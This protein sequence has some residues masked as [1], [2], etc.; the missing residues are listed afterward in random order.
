MAGVVRRRGKGRGRARVGE[1]LQALGY[2]GFTVDDKFTDTTAA[3]VGKWQKD[4]GHK[5][6]GRFDPGDAVVLP[7]SVRVGEVTAT[8]GGTSGKNLTVGAG[9][10][11]PSDCSD[12]TNRRLKSQKY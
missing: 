3:A 11:H 4:V 9:P 1:N 8:L 12:C 5:Q 6:T 10:C 7:D 2:G